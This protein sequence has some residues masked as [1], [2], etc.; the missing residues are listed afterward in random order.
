MLQTQVLPIERALKIDRSMH[1]S[2]GIYGASQISISHLGAP[3][4]FVELVKLFDEIIVPY[5]MY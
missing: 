1:S 5:G 2:L 4:S 3:S